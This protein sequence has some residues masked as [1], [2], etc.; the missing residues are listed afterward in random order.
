MICLVL[1]CFANLNQW[2][3]DTT[4]IRSG[5][6]IVSA[7]VYGLPWDPEAVAETIHTDLEDD[8]SRQLPVTITQ[9]QVLSPGKERHSSA[10]V[11][12]RFSLH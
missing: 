8:E 2:T 4:K 7:R 9:G 11:D 3:N 6:E 10:F 5:G 1:V 12:D